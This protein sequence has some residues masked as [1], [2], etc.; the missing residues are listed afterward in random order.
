MP[1]YRTNVG[2]DGTIAL[3]PDLRERLRIREGCEVE[4]FLT[5]DGDVFFHAITG[6]AKD[7]T[8]KFDVEVRAPPISIQE[9][10]QGIAEHIVEDHNRILRQGARDRQRSR[11]PAAE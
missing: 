1:V 10:D 8:G 2:P 5:L 7:W 11:R 6:R 4:F 3:P 9:M